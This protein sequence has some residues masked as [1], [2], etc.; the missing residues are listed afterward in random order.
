MENIEQFDG[1]RKTNARLIF[2]VLVSIVLI[3]ALFF[4]T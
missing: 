1:V 3:D 4:R 2:T